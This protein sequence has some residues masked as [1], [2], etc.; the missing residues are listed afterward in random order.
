MGD[1]YTICGTL[2]HG[3]YLIES[4]ISIMSNSTYF[5]YVELDFFLF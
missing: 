4:T 1:L 5:S 2:E 3:H